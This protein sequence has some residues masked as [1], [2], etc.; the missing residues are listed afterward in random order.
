MT[1]KPNPFRG[2][3]PG[4][5]W[6]PLAALSLLFFCPSTL[7][8]PTGRP[9]GNVSAA[10]LAELFEQGLLC[11][12]EHVSP[13]DYS[14]KRRAPNFAPSCPL[15]RLASRQV[16]NEDYSCSETKPCSNGACCSKITGYCNYGPEACGTNG[17]SPNDVCWSNCD[18]HAECGSQYGFCGMTAEFCTKGNSSEEGCQ[19]NCEQ[20][21]SGKSGSNVQKKVIGY[22]EAWAHDRKCTGMD[23]KDI[24]V[25]ALTHLYF[26]FGYISPGD[27]NIVPMDNL[28]FDLFNKLTDLKKRNSG[29]KCVIALGGWTFNDPGLTQRVFS[30]VVSTRQ[31]RARFIANLLSFL[32][33]F[34][35]DG[36]DFDWEYPG[37]ADRGGKPEDGVNFTKLLKELRKAIANEPL[38]YIVS[39]TVPTSY[40][41][42]RHFDLKAID[43]VDFVNVMSYDLH[44]T[45]DSTNPVGNHVL[46]HTNLTEIKLALDLMWRN[47][48]DPEKLNI[49]IGFYGRS[50]Q[51][52]DPACYKPG[53]N[54]KGEAAP[55]GCTANSGTLSYKEIMHIIKEHNLTPFYDK[56]SQVKYIVWN[57]DQWVS[58]DDE[59]TFKAKIKFANALGLGGLLIWS[60]D[61]DTPDLSALK[62]I[63][64]PQPLNVF[65][66]TSK[67]A[68]YWHD[69]TAQ[70]CYVTGCGG[71]CKPGFIMVTK[72]PC[73]GAKRVT[74]HSTQR[75]STLCC[76]I[77]S[78]PNPDT[79]RWRGKPP[80]CNGQCHEGE[81][82]LQMNRWGDTKYCE[83]G[84]KFYCCDVP[85]GKNTGCYWTSA[86]GSCNE[87]DELMRKTFSGTFLSTFADIARLG[88]L[89]G[90]V[91]AEI[92][93][94]ADIELEY[95][96]CCSRGAMKRWKKLQL[97]TQDKHGGGQSCF[98]RL[99]RK[100]VF[101]CDAAEGEPLF[102][103][104]PLGNLF[105]NAPEADDAV[106]F[107][108]Q[109][110][111]TW[112]DGGEDTAVSDDP[113]EATFGFWVL[114]SPEEIQI[115]LDKRDGSHWELF[116]CQKASSDPD[117]E[118]TV[119]MICTDM[120]NESN[121]DKIYLGHGAAGT[122]VGLPKGCGP[123]KYAVVKSLEVSK[124]QTLP[125]H[126]DRRGF[127]YKPVV[128][129]L[130][131]DFEWRRVPR[132]FGETQMRIDYSNEI[133][134]WDTIVE[135]A[136][137][138]KRKRSLTDTNGSHKRWLEDEWRDDVHFGA[139]SKEELHK[140]WFGSDI[141]DW[142]R[143]LL[144]GDISPQFTHDIDQSFTAIL[145]QEKWGPCMIGGVEVTATLDARATANVKVA[146]SFG[147]TII[148][149]LTFPPDLSQSYLYFKNKG[150]VSAI[151]TL[152]A[153][154]KATYKTGDFEIFGLD[155]FPGATFSIPKILT[156]G[157][158]FK[159]FA[160]AEAD[161]ALHG[162]LESR[163]DIASWDI[164]Q[165]YPNPSS[166][167]DPKALTAPS[168]EMTLKG[169]RP[170]TFDY[171]VKAEGQLTAH[172]K[173]TFIFG[174]DFDKMWK[175]DGAKVELVADG[176]MRM[177]ASAEISNDP[178]TC[179]FQYGIDVGADL[180]AKLEVPSAFGSWNGR[181]FPIASM[182]PK[183]LVQGNTCPVHTK[184]DLSNA[185]N[186]NGHMFGRYEMGDYNEDT[187]VAGYNA[188][189][190]F[191]SLGKRSTFG[192]VIR[193][194]VNC[195]YCPNP[196]VTSSTAC[197]SI[198]G[199]DD[200]EVNDPDLVSRRSFDTDPGHLNFYE[201][202]TVKKITFCGGK[203][204]QQMLFKSAA[205]ESS[206]TIVLSIPSIKTYGPINPALCNDFSFGLVPNKLKNQ[207]SVQ[208]ATEHVL[209][210]QL[211]PIFLE[212]LDT[213][214]GAK[215]ENPVRA[216]ATTTLA[217]TTTTN[218]AA[219]P[220]SVRLCKY[221]KPYWEGSTITIPGE[222]VPRAAIHLLGLGFPGM[223]N[224]YADEFI[225]L[226]K[227]V[228]TAKELMWGDKSM[229]QSTKYSKMLPGDPDKLIKNV[230]DCIM[231][232]KYHQ[233]P[234]IKAIL[235]KQVNRIADRFETI[236]T[237]LAGQ[238]LQGLN[239]YVKK[240]LKNE[241]KTFMKTRTLLAIEKVELHMDTV[242]ADLIKGYGGDPAKE[243]DPNKKELKLKIV[244]LEDAVKAVK[245]TWINPF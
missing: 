119:Q 164:Q 218:A 19:S 212:D 202:R 57:Q 105:P 232:Y 225:I 154:G 134:Y 240:G 242:V 65:L 226:A 195:L 122:I 71:S 199:W 80:D 15:H 196:P 172:L 126:L 153:V 143:N 191:H 133:G 63:L 157:P 206:G 67:D 169:L 50:F 12:D 98:P 92:L 141:I 213:R 170:P 125:S 233:I 163:V 176:W 17:Q 228:N 145:L 183:K 10:G 205:Y 120:S 70:D 167:Y 123:S 69:V 8:H 18:A 61:Q 177:Y 198:S 22:Y 109:I 182:K 115:S 175:V 130:T 137:S 148:T 220:K 142:L 178:N 174:I 97:L 146:T 239:Q 102:P 99:E 190:E 45:W 138:S 204:K 144:S 238:Q 241:W 74:R 48:V 66:T 223:H 25:G 186:G 29:L 222:P 76:P 217:A 244:A 33:Q 224:S 237:I 140:R 106:E 35:F 207:G 201:K 166:Q 23:F 188:S 96:Y 129:D 209:E 173:P 245:G 221:M 42:L 155:N 197:E 184:R 127:G 185:L 6:I 62:A 89:F 162:H 72:Q 5:F 131:F 151:F 165:T 54:F 110:D 235:V 1:M 171:S 59:E 234:E 100:R 160:S 194:P 114:T 121:C 7:A 16:T 55:G 46:A 41:Y 83:N 49:G 53:C 230:K 64:D 4:D 117:G 94:A 168:R 84:H 36:V 104:V 13:Y 78:A 152:D 210:F 52:S 181:T 192:P 40:W 3:P 112:G 21:R 39:F 73:G 47:D 14:V 101:C 180:M 227:G 60:V 113:D 82:A 214:W 103:P 44:G 158:N 26:S 43:H 208:F 108:L 150:E 149:T 107:D 124:N 27:F 243:T 86:G 135:K 215:L 24:P 34:A 79:C 81:V 77:T 68:S 56:K 136:A 32:R 87:G 231:A 38:K 90:Q 93:N 132:D 116:N 31:N 58:Y 216:T 9:H 219:L 95:R 51:L 37:A 203:G 236:E 128:H 28:A 118:S 88:G 20:P 187:A 30:D 111:N 161:V 11:W 2:R 159:L 211:V 193:I 85:A 139:L 189:S 156:V 179:P 91:L 75:D 200:D 229:I 147:L